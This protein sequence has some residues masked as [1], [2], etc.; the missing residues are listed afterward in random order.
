MSSSSS[1]STSS[2]SYEEDDSSSEDMLDLLSKDKFK[3][4]HI[5]ANLQAGFK[6]CHGDFDEAI[7]EISMIQLFAYLFHDLLAKTRKTTATSQDYT[8]VYFTYDRK[9][10]IER[11]IYWIRDFCTNNGLCFDLIRE[12]VQTGYAGGID[13]GK[14][15]HKFK[16]NDS[17]SP[18]TYIRR[19]HC[20]I[21]RM[22]V[23][24]DIEKMYQE[25]QA[26]DAQIKASLKN[27]QT[28]EKRVEQLEA[29]LK[30]SS[31]SDEKPA[32][33]TKE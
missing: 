2:S 26:K 20:S 23:C 12:Q 29:Q 9:A 10:D 5:I 11:T 31:A 24:A 4:A 15:L 19:S 22:T 8:D 27:Y 16:K 18:G 21:Y 13:A 6:K 14:L 17:K 25:S 1:D 30:N 32:D 28:L 7:H 3:G 33:E